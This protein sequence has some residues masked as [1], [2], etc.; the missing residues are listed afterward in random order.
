M[1]TSLQP[2]WEKK[3]RFL[4]QLL[5]WSGALNIGLL[6]SLIYLVLQSRPETISFDLKPV[7][8]ASTLQAT[9]QEI[10]W[11]FSTLSWAELIGQ[12]GND[13]LVEQGYKKRDLAL[14]SLVAFHGFDI[15]RALQGSF[16]QKRGIA[17]TRKEGPEEINLILYPG[18]S[19][20][21]FVAIRR[22]IQTEK[23]PFTALGLFYEI[24]HAVL[25]RD[26]ALLEAFY[27]TPEFNSIATLCQ[28]TGIH[29]PKEFIIEMIAQGDWK[30]LHQFATEQKE[31]MDLT[32][33][34]LKKLLFSYVKCRSVLAA[35][36][37]LQSDH[38]FILKRLDDRDLIVFLDLFKEPSVAL[39]ELLKELITSA[40]SDT[41]WKKAAELLY[42][43]GGLQLPEPY[44][45][46]VTLAAFAGI[47]LPAQKIEQP[48]VTVLPPKKEEL[49]HTIA[50]GENLWKIARKYKVSVEALRK[51]NRL[52]TDKLREGKTLII[53]IKE[54][55]LPRQDSRDGSGRSA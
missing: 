26:P 2:Q 8:A 49:K 14:A 43:F 19:E 30:T 50:H 13:D 40:R 28:R 17:L 23:F 46:N 53:P 1:D 15:E 48:V 12:L 16:I 5:I 4:T 37:L 29:L 45:H 18:L 3:S 52:E 33:D 6:S 20:D 36:I 44:D 31:G 32:P 7:A 51:A 47:A 42:Q 27:L 22:F 25:P 55:D 34:R 35:K 24:Q 10:L 21:Q 9:N 41:V 11:Q 54:Q 39:K 38:E